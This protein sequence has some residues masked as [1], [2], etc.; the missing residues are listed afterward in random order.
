[1][2][3][4]TYTIYFVTGILLATCQLTTA[5]N[6]C[7]HCRMDIKDE[8]FK[9][10]ATKDSGEQVSFDAIEC[11][12]NFT[13][14]KKSDKITD[15]KVADYLSGNMIAAE[16]AYYLK[17]KALPS[18]MGANLS[19]YETED[20]ALKQRKALGGEVYNWTELKKRFVESNFG[21]VHS[22]HHGINHYATAGIGGDHLHPKGGMMLSVRYMHMFMEGNRQ[23]D[24]RVDDSTV[25][26][27]YMVAPQNMDMRM[28]MLG[29]MYAPSDRT[30]LML[31]QNVVWKD[32][33]LT[34]RMQMGNGM[35]MFNDFSTSSSGLGD[36]KLG[37]LYGLGS[38]EKNSVHLNTGLN[39]PIGDVQVTGDTPMGQDVKLPYAMQLGSGTFDLLLGATFRNYGTKFSYGVQQLNT[40]RTG[41]NSEGYR[42]GNLYELHTWGAYNFNSEF[43]TTLRISG[44]ISESIKGND[45]DLNPMMVTTADPEN[46]GGEIIRSAIGFNGLVAKNTLF[47]GMEFSVPL[48][49]QYNGVQMDER[50]GLD[51]SVRYTIL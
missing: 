43:N 24:E 42:F 26:E 47:L 27:D 30:T 1:M 12:I 5:Q 7:V 38:G 10:Q 2:R 33:D 4:L 37:F 51:I 40:L 13:K 22:H 21:S 44:S 9:A 36:L 41:E 50:W 28:L 45:P 49:R 11:L 32:M 23:G 48:Y 46:Y 35:P 34:A 39:I 15:L 31:M 20:M 14:N 29:F 17:S 18:P 25:Y 8:L 6:S 16:K 3:L 19:A